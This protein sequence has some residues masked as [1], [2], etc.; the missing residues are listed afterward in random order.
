LLLQIAAEVE[1]KA[2]AEADR[3]EQAAKAA[4][5]EAARYESKQKQLQQKLARAAEERE[6][7]QHQKQELAV[8]PAGVVVVAGPRLLGAGCRCYS[9]VTQSVNG[10]VVVIEAPVA[11][12]QC[13]EEN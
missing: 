12:T 1:L 2:A 10:G 8:R 5:A 11:L 7:M 13:Q 4:E 3:L 9:K 6:Q